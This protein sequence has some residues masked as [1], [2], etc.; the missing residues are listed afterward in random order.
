MTSP[1]LAAARRPRSLLRTGGLFVLVSVVCGLLVTALTLPFVGGAAW[2]AKTARDGMASLPLEFDAPAQAQRSRVLDAEGRTIAYF[3]DQNRTYTKLADIAPVMRTALIS[4]ED[5]RFYEHG[6]LDAQG[7]VR[8][9]VK[10]FFAGGVT[11]GGS[12]LTQQYVKQVQVNA[13]ALSGDE[14]AVEAATDT[15]YQRKLRELRYAVSVE[16]TMS[17]DQILERY[18]NIAYFGDG[19][20]GIGAA[21]QHYFG[22]SAKKLTLPQAALLAGLVQNPNGYDPVAHPDAGIERRNVVLDRMAEL[23]TASQAAVTKAKKTSFSEKQVTEVA[24]GCQSTDL[25]FVCDYVRRT[26][27]Q[28][29]SLG[30][31]E[32]DREKLLMRGGLTIRTAIDPDTQDEVQEKVND[33]VSAKD[34]VISVMDMIEPGTGKIVAMAQS[35]PVMGSDAKK[36]QTYWNYSASPEMGGAQ[37]FQAGSTFKAFT[38]AAALENGIPLAKRYNARAKMDFSGAD[39]DSC[40]GSTRVVG[41]FP[42]ENSTGV[43][44]NMDMYRA[45]E[46][47]VNTYF[48]QLALDVGMCDVTKMAEKLGVQSSTP[49]RPISWYDDK[50]SFTLGTAEVSPLS[51]ANAYATFASGGIHCNPVIVSKI[52]DGSGKD[53]EVPGADCKRVISEDVASAMDSLLSSVVT[54]G[55]GARARTAD[56]RPQA[57]KTGTIDSNAAVWYVGYTP[58]IAGA[59][60]I[61]IDK[62][63]SSRTSLKGYTVPSSGLY[64][65]GSGSGDAG[66]RIWKPVMEDYLDGKPKESFPTPPVDLVRGDPSDRTTSNDR[67]SQYG[68]DGRPGGR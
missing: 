6:P 11:Q 41:D 10:N 17:K 36:G 38:A 64:L 1:T 40:E 18:L 59:A 65:E 20:Y 57:G 3:Y 27:L 31:T 53:R 26:V 4:I 52:T 46:F 19:A 25:P 61:S 9:F 37:G 2:G 43:N 16:D 34:P 50:P 49:D 63:R 8:A 15:S 56:G 28:M 66:R 47:S 45:A 13:A 42:V 14:A 32:A 58:Q 35:R 48:V 24:S 68:Q 62:E 60:M 12:T 44:G 30:K 33:A 7:T 29:P 55:T 5:H 51:V 21:S 22:T 67:F 39:F 54:K 23:G